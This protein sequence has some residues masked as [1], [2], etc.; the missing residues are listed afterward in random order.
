MIFLTILLAFIAASPALGAPQ[1]SMGISIPLTEYSLHGKEDM[2]NLEAD[3]LQDH[4][5]TMKCPA[6]V[7]K[8]G[9]SQRLTS[10]FKRQKAPLVKLKRSTW[11]AKM[12]IGTPPQ[13]FVVILDTGSDFTWLRAPISQENSSTHSYDPKKSLTSELVVEEEIFSRAYLGGTAVEGPVLAD[14]VT[15]GGLVADNQWFASVETAGKKAI[16]KEGLFG[17]CFQK[18][19]SSIQE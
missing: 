8:T 12:Q 2:I 14:T 9:V 4:C 19:Q 17:T 1:K 7:K 16:T 13:D 6:K 15:I 5:D 18:S 10:L 3:A 11:G